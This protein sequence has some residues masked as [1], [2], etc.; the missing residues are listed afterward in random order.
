MTIRVRAEPDRKFLSSAHRP[1]CPQTVSTA[2]AIGNSVT[3]LSSR[4]KGSSI[5]EIDG[6]EGTTY[7][8]KP[9]D[10]IPRSA[11]G[12]FSLF[13][14]GWVI[15][16]LSGV[17]MLVKKNGPDNFIQVWLVAWTFG[18][19][20]VAVIVYFL[21]RAG[22]AECLTLGR[23]FL[24]HAPGRPPMW[25]VLSPWYA[26]QHRDPFRPFG[27]LFQGRRPVEVSKDDLG[28]VVLTRVGERQRLSFDHGADRIEIGNTFGSRTGSG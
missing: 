19:L 8:W 5:E 6:P 21:S 24:R 27:S 3:E 18:G 17:A 23:G 1:D 2:L 14:A 12:I 16:L 10:R 7:R 9:P 22:R 28:P 15:G 20:Q 26:L 25:M 11:I 4:P 13:I